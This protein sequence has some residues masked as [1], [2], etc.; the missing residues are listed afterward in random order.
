MT[1]T[2]TSSKAVTTAAPTR[3][4][5]DT[6]PYL[7]DSLY[8]SGLAVRPKATD[9]GPTWELRARLSRGLGVA[10]NAH[11]EVLKDH[12]GALPSNALLVEFMLRDYLGLPVPRRNS[13]QFVKHG[14]V[15]RLKARA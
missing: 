10:L 4:G 2:T 6:N 9:S 14:N 1:I 7:N 11:R 5:T 13:R 12:F 8:V 3:A 15:R